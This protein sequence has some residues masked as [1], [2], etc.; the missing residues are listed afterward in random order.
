LCN[1][2]VIFGLEEPL[3]MLKNELDLGGRG[4]CIG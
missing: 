4:L 3:A 1:K 2:Y